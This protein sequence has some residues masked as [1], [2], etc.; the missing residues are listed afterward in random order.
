MELPY[1]SNSTLKH[2]SKRIEK[3]NQ[4]DICTLMLFTPFFITKKKVNTSQ[5]PSIDK[6]YSAIKWSEVL[7]RT[8]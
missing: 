8:T 7:T 5:Y 6:Y 1:E 3:G 4:I 2:I